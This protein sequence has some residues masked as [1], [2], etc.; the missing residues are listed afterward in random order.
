MKKFT[1][2]PRAFSMEQGEITP[3]MKLRRRIIEATYKQ[4]ID[5]M[6]GAS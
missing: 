5:A 6:Y 1:L 2:L 4:E 3:T